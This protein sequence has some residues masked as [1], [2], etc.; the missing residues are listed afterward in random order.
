MRENVYLCSYEALELRM[1]ER[2]LGF[3]LMLVGFTEGLRKQGFALE[4]ILPGSWGNSMIEDI[5][6]S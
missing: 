5:N 6:K 4:W 3:G 1:L 2:V